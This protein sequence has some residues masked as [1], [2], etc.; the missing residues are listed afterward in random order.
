MTPSISVKNSDVQM[1]FHSDWLKNNGESA[2]SIAYFWSKLLIYELRRYFGRGDC[3]Q[4]TSVRERTALHK[5]LVTL[6]SLISIELFNVFFKGRSY[7]VT[8]L[9]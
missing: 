3:S 1:R 7:D 8:V 9:C 2:K 6:H 5:M 4:I